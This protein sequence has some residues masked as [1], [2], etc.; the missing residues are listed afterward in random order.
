MKCTLC[1][2]N[3]GT[4]N[5]PLGPEGDDNAEFLLVL[6]ELPSSSDFEGTYLCRKRGRLIRECLESAGLQRK[7]VII[8][9]ASGCRA[10]GENPLLASLLAS[11]SFKSV[12]ALGDN[13]L[14]YLCR[15]TGVREKRGRAFPFHK[16]F[17]LKGDVWSTWGMGDALANPNYKKVIIQDI[18]K[19][20]SQNEKQQ[21]EEIEWERWE[22][23]HLSGDTI[24]WDIEA[25]DDKGGYTDYPTLVSCAGD[26]FCYVSYNTEYSVRGLLQQLVQASNKG[27]TLTGHNI[28]G[29]DIPT[30]AKFGIQMPT[31]MDTM[32]LA[33]LEDETQS[34]GLESLCVKH[35]QT[36]GWK[37]EIKN[38]VASDELA[39]YA[40]KDARY[41]LRLYRRLRKILGERYRIA[42][43][44]LAPAYE[45]FSKMSERGIFLSASKIAEIRAEE[46]QKLKNATQK[47]QALVGPNFRPSSSA[48]VAAFLKAEGHI[49][50][51]TESGNDQTSVGVL[52]DIGGDFCDAVLG[53]R[54]ASKTLSTYI[55]NY[56]KR[57]MEDS[58]VHSTFKIW[59]A[60]TGRSTSSKLNV[61]NNM[62]EHKD[63]FAAPP[64]KVLAQYDY[65]AVEFR[66]AAW[67]AQEPTILENF[68][69]DAD[70]D[71]H[72]YFASVLYK[73]PQSEVTKQ[74]RQ[75][76]KSGNFG[77]CFLG[78]AHTLVD[79]M[80]KMGIKL[81][82]E[83]CQEI[84]TTWHKAFPG[85]AK[86]YKEVHEE[87]MKTDCSTTAT[88]HVRHYG[89]F[90]VLNH[91][92]KVEALRE[93]VNVKAQGLAAHIAFIALAELHKH[94][95]QIVNFVH[96]SVVIEWDSVEEMNAKQKLIQRSMCSVPVQRMQEW[97]NVNFDV[98]LLI[99][100][101]Y[102]EY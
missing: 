100:R 90:K 62:R 92:K 30:V 70:W 46:E 1:Q 89:D 96:D 8:T 39:R 57:L 21:E 22:G 87:L 15:K 80:G 72:K 4:I 54:R 41:T 81:T 25:L 61:Q 59:S 17:G 63:I 74:E 31:G 67:C 51:V 69:K 99:D 11:R 16:S 64:G 3:C 6:D 24:A 33:Y 84:Y 56:E 68:K 7:S 50:P 49:L 78:N 10:G 2:T 88:G 52:K 79:Y 66:V 23:Q 13:A 60:R 75:I 38:H 65:K 95:L 71:P 18:R 12:I 55:V 47:L 19:A 40:A 94:D 44:I 26:G 53:Y 36:T 14:R 83:E 98:P 37:E 48:E 29:Y 43:N 91:Y 32:V 82:L 97:F 86:W 77:L 85:F 101:E 9:S 45:A 42:T 76:A 27:S 34:K 35:F 102:K 28:Y 93:A 20:L 73:K 5:G 58:R